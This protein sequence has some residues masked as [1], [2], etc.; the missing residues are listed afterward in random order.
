MSQY[1]VRFLEK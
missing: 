1:T